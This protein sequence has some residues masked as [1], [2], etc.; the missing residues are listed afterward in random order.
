[1]TAT[2]TEQVKPSSR[3]E[4][5]QDEFETLRWKRRIF[6]DKVMKGVL[7]LAFILVLVPLLN[8]IFMVII[9]GLEVILK[10]EFYLEEGRSPIVNEGGIAHA[11]VGTLIVTTIGSIIGIPLGLIVGIYLGEFGKNGLGEIVRLF[12]ETMAGIPTIISGIVAYALIVVT[13]NGFSALAGG[14]AL[15]IIMIPI[16]ARTTDEMIRLVPDEHREAAHALGLNTSTTVLNVVLPSARKGIVT[17]ILLAVARVMGETA[18]LLFTALYTQHLNFNLT[19][20]VA[21]LTTLIFTYGISPFDYWQ[22]LAW[23]AAF[24]LLVLN[25]VIVLLV[26]HGKSSSQQSSSA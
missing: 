21:T 11:L 3:M 19:Y 25:L 17:G 18:P 13:M 1:M 12:V 8:I 10:P 4:E 5:K 9:N 26:R 14:I 7:F 20:P 23:G 22:K 16:I 24:L 2:I 15:G 6:V